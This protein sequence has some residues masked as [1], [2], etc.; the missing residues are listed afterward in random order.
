MMALAS[1]SM[2]LPRCLDADRPA[3]HCPALGWRLRACM[4]SSAMRASVHLEA[5]DAR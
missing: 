1:A 5:S 4:A 3:L 2:S